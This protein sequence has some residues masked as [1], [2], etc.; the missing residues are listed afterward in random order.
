MSP[1]FVVMH[2]CDPHIRHWPPK[3]LPSAGSKAHLSRLFPCEGPLPFCPPGAWHCILAGGTGW[4]GDMGQ[5]PFLPPTPTP[6]S[7]TKSTDPLARLRGSPVRFQLP[8]YA[9]LSRFCYVFFLPY[10][11][12]HQQRGSRVLCLTLLD[13]PPPWGPIGDNLAGM[14]L[15]QKMHHYSLSLVESIAAHRAPVPLVEPSERFSWPWCPAVQSNTRGHVSNSVCHPLLWAGR[16]NRAKEGGGGALLFR[17]IKCF[18]F[19]CRAS[20]SRRRCGHPSG[21]RGRPADNPP[22]SP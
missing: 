2:T 22:H 15:A 17:S 21:G 8:V 14:G 12:P 3:Q 10:G 19:G 20:C 1:H 7:H 13:W 5:L 6:S 18:A 9:V 11:P 4:R 16:L